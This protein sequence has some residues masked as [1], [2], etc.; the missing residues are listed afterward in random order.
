[1][2]KFLISVN[3]TQYEVD[4]EEVASVSGETSAPHV[5]AQHDDKQAA[6]AKKAPAETP[7]KPKA[8][9][10]P[11]PVSVPAPKAGSETISCPMP[12]T[13]LKV[14]V[15]PGQAVKKNQ[16]LYVIESMK[17]ENEVVSPRD[18]VVASVMITRGAAVN[19]GDPMISLE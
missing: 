18:G 12:G 19:A 2:K 7:E 10:H 14:A 15:K 13:I 4:V 11:A 8:A 3:G 5:K 6:A 17:M 16:L 9:A 1:M